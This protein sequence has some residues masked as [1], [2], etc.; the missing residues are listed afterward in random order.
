MMKTIIMA[1]GKGT[2]IA[3]IADDIPKS[4]IPICGKPILE[5]QITCLKKNGL[6][7]I[8]LVVGHLGQQIQDYFGDG[9]KFGCNISYFGETDPLGTAGALYKVKN[10]PSDF[11]LLNGDTI[12]D[13]DFSRMISFH[14]EKKAWATLAVH[15]NDHPFDSALISSDSNNQIV[16]WLNKE[17]DRLYYKN[18]VNAG[19]HILSVKLLEN[20]PQTKDKID[21][22]RD[23]LKPMIQTGKVFAYQTPEY[24]K[25]MGTPERYAQVF[26]DIENG[27]VASRNLGFA[28]KAVF[29]D[30]D[31][32]INT[33]S[34][35]V[36][37]PEDLE[38]TV[39]AAEAIR[40]INGLGFLAIVITNQP[41]IARGDVDFATLNLIHKKMETEL[42]KHGAFVD[43]IFFC[44][45][46]PDK[47]YPGE[48]PEYKTD[49]DCR[50]PKPGMILQ[51]AQKYNVDLSMS[52]MVGDGMRDARAGMNAG[53]VPILLSDEELP[54]DMKDVETFA[55]LPRFAKWLAQQHGEAS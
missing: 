12:F 9:S 30:R 11:V 28:Q 26:A 33:L 29:L 45:H 21:L 36:T 8:T 5:H 55:N 20:C 52:Y 42:G 35:F 51:A 43:D 10:L 4:M 3:S 40:T 14:H 46:H 2:R 6:T 34:G 19:I 25:D 53:C 16:G 17:D 37:R 39:G 38:L 41:V 1:G 15:P 49:C 18:I 47:G 44:P 22:D 48:R 13:I 24:I 23:M 50:K 27:I 32:T 31:G 7:N 54:E